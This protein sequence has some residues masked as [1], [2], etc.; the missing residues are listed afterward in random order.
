MTRDLS[1][2]AR[3]DFASLD[4]FHAEIKEARGEDVCLDGSQVS[5]L[6]SCGLQL[7][8]SA[9]K[10][11]EQDGHSL[12]IKNPSQKFNDHIQQLGLSSEMFGKTGGEA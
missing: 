2:P 7:L 6:G 12:T 11:W 8:I 10:A 9:W 4:A 1:L 3:M 5:H